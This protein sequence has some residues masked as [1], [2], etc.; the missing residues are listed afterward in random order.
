MESVLKKEVDEPDSW[1]IGI[2][3]I[4]HKGVFL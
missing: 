4:F 3:P 1:S 2:E